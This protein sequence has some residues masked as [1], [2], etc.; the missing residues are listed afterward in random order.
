[1]SI[2]NLLAESRR[3]GPALVVRDCPD[4]AR[5]IVEVRLARSPYH[6][7]RLTPEERLAIL[8]QTGAW[9]DD[10]IPDAWCGVQANDNKGATR[11]Q[12]TENYEV[13]GELL[14]T[15]IMSGLW[16]GAE[17]APEDET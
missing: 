1:M 4:G 9:P 16:A 6:A 7:K 5:E 2:R 3:S 12:V 17:D 13:Y 8:T 15:G 11:Q 14:R 10:F